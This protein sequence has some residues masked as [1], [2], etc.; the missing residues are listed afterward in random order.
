MADATFYQAGEPASDHVIDPVANSTKVD[1]NILLT[2][3]V[4][5]YTAMAV[6]SVGFFVWGYGVTGGYI[7]NW[8][9]QVLIGLIAAAA[10]AFITDLAFR[11]F[12]EDVVFQVLAGPMLKAQG[13]QFQT[14]YVRKLRRA[15]LFMLTGIVLLLFAADVFSVYTIKDPFAN[16]AK[17]RELVDVEARRTTWVEGSTAQLNPMAGQIKTLKADIAAAE[18]RVVTDNPGLRKLAREKNTWAIQ[19]LANKKKAASKSM[20]AELEK[21]TASYNTSLAS[22]AAQADTSIALINTLNKNAVEANDRDRSALSG[23][24]MFFGG[25]SK[26]LAVLCRVFLV[27][28]FLSLNPK[29]W[30]ANKD[31]KIDGSDATAAARGK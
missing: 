31:G 22:N 19:Q 21:L 10:A 12:L 26:V 30:D 3:T 16:K 13:A 23:M 24:F 17:G 29:L 15:R 2:E 11:K 7:Q 9:V 6:T 18:S 25:G 27:I 14:G 8:Y 28:S 5:V 20:R 4:A 1:K